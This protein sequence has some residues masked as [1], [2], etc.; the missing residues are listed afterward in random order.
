MIPGERITRER[1]LEAADRIGPHVRRTPVMALTAGELGVDAEVVL[2]LEL[3]QHT[4]SFKPRGAFCRMLSAKVPEAGV[5]AASG[6]NH[7]LA[8]AYAA[9][10]LGYRAEIFLP[11]LSPAFKVE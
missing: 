10:K 7:G 2:K 4:G 3:L 1:I 6:G 9:A 8:V 5:T 11:S